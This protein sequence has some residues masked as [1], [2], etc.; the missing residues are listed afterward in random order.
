MREAL[1]DEDAVLDEVSRETTV[2]TAHGFSADAFHRLPPIY[3]IGDS[4]SIAFRN[5]VYVSE[6]TS[7]AYQLRSVHLRSLH[8]ADFFSREHALAPP[9]VSA[10]ATDQTIISHDDGEHWIVNRSEFVL[11]T[12]AAPLVLFCGVHDAHRVMDYLG[13]DGDIPAWDERS[14]RFD[15]TK[16]PVS[17]LVSAEDALQRVLELMEPFALG[18]EALKTMG[19]HRIFVHGCPCSSD[20]T[21][22]GRRSVQMKGMR[23]Y[24]PNAGGKVYALIDEAIRS[25]ARRTSARYLAGPV[26]AR[27]ELPAAVTWDD[28]HY[29]ADGARAVARSVVSVLEGVV[30]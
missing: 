20:S 3:F 5:A 23:Q 7:R 10:L 6:F 21:R 24:H 4:R 25:I 16:K 11:D 27:G 28:V 30:E 15:A 26:D 2:P 13:P 17:R 19:F 8:A 29:N 1:C 12:D 9:L 14:R 22:A 18:I